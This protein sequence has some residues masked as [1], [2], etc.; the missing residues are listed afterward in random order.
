M[1]AHIPLLRC[2]PIASRALQK[3]LFLL[4]KRKEKNRYYYLL[5]LKP[6]AL[7]SFQFTKYKHFSIYI[8]IYSHMSGTIF[9]W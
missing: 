2:E 1:K 8:Y 3:L 7:C 5:V 9:V 4:V 6:Q